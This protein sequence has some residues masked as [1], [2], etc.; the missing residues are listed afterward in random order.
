MQ[1]PRGLDEER[2]ARWIPALEERSAESSKSSQHPDHHCGTPWAQRPY[3]AA[4]GHASL[5][6][7]SS[8][9]SKEGKVEKGK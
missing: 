1:Q 6:S 5:P 3:V 8:L 7:A 4:R 9:P 2:G